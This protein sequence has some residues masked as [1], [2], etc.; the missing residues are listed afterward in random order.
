MNNAG[1]GSKL[2]QIS[3]ASPVPMYQ[4]IQLI[5]RSEIMSC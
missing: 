5:L 3:A 4:Q 2:K 1:G